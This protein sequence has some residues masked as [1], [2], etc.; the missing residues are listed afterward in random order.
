MYQEFVASFEDSHKHAGG[1]TWV[2][3]GTVNADKGQCLVYNLR[4]NVAE[5]CKTLCHQTIDTWLA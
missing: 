1:K 2:K 5:W 4:C 3:G